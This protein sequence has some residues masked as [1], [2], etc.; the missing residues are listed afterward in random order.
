[1]R[2]AKRGAIKKGQRA[3]ILVGRPSSGQS[4]IAGW[5][6]VDATHGYAHKH[7]HA[8]THTHTHARMH[9]HPTTP[10]HAHSHARTHAYTHAHPHARTHMHAHTHTHARTRTHAHTSLH[11]CIHTHANWIAA[12]LFDLQCRQ[13]SQE[14]EIMMNSTCVWVDNTTAIA[15]SI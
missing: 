6:S 10:T 13:V 15:P 5:A 1:M 4:A 11:I 3:G 8:P 12:I 7:P 14:Q 9:M 2:G